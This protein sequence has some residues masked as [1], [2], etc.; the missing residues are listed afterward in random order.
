MFLLSSCLAQGTAEEW[1]IQARCYEMQGYQDL[2]LKAYERAC[3]EDSS[4]FLKGVLSIRYLRA[5]RFDKIDSIP[6]GLINLDEYN[7]GN[8]I[9][10]FYCQASDT[11][12]AFE[13]WKSLILNA[14]SNHQLDSAL[15]IANTFAR[16]IPRSVPRTMQAYLIRKVSR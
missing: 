12:R 16:K 9:A 10:E 13:L 4:S 7:D 14:V 15:V 2:A 8:K 1:F 5:G 11:V 3:N 6:E